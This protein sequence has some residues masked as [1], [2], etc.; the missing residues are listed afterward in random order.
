MGK[1]YFYVRN[2]YGN[3]AYES[4]EEGNYLSFQIK[5]SGDTSR[6]ERVYFRTV[7][8]SAKAGED[9]DR[10]SGWAYFNPGQ[11]TAGVM[12][13]TREDYTPEGDE[14]FELVT[15]SAQYE[16]YPGR[17]YSNSYVTTGNARGYGTIKNDDWGYAAF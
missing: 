13:R 17:F 2:R 10:R 5:R 12:V 9:Y 8:G 6:R 4:Q 1:S 3:S 15:S 16:G 14:R 11:T 7:D